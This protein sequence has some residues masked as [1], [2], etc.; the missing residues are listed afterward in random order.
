ME[1][2]LKNNSFGMGKPSFSNSSSLSSFP[3]P[4]GIS[5]FGNNSNG[6]GWMYSTFDF[7]GRHP[8]TIGAI[9]VI[10]PVLA[11]MIMGF[12]QENLKLGFTSMFLIAVVIF[13]AYLYNYKLG[14]AGHYGLLIILALVSFCYM[15]YFATKLKKTVDESLYLNF[16][17]PTTYK[18][19]AP[20]P[21]SYAQMS[22]DPD[23]LLKLMDGNL[24]GF[25]LKEDM[26]M[27]LGTEGTYSFWLKVCP[28][29][30]NKLNTNWRTVWFRGDTSGDNGQSIYKMKTPGVYLAPNTNKLIITVACENGPD[31]GNAITIDDIPLNEWFCVTISLEGR[32]FDCY[33]NGLLE[34]SISLTGAPLMMNSNIVKG[35]NGF[36]GLMAFFRYNAGSL[37]PVDIK[38]MYDMEKTTLEGMGNLEPCSIES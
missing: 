28:S 15:V 27:D 23:T 2:F 30:F 38:S 20:L 22:K 34:Y 25:A 12:I 10:I 33:I 35:K 18:R 4:S 8:V 37:L 26:P 3:G 5:G 36:N 6:L 13:L 24:Y 31:E 29:N 32:S 11:L 21:L 1:A 19:N 16:Y 7:I 17:N 14:D 9:L